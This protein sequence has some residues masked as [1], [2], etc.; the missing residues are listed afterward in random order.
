MGRRF[1]ERRECEGRRESLCLC[2]SGRER[3]SAF[4]LPS[5]LD[6]SGTTQSTAFA[7]SGRERI[8]AFLLPSG[9]LGLKHG[10]EAESR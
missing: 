4:L 2:A 9:K 6:T 7:A 8:S 5:G 3:I 10:W 1:G